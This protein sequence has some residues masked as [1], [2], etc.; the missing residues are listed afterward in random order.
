VAVGFESGS[1]GSWRSSEVVMADASGAES[2]GA[3]EEEKFG[4][5]GSRG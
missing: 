2:T 4:G 5:G 3:E 1:A